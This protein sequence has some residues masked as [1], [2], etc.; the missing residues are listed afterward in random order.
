M[1][2]PGIAYDDGS[3]ADEFVPDG[4]ARVVGQPGVFQG[5]LSLPKLRAAQR[6]VPTHVSS[7]FASEAHIGYEKKGLLNS[8]FAT[9]HSPTYYAYRR[10]GLPTR[11]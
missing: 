6:S 3:D 11:A 5:G 10:T 9:L 1:N 7:C 8:S 4:G 2:P